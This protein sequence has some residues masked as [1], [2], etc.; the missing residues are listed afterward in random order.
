MDILTEQLK[1]EEGL[2]LTAYP[3]PTG[4]KTIGYGHNLEA[5]PFFEGNRIPD[6]ITKQVAEVLL[7]HD[8]EDT[9]ELLDKAWHGF[10]LLPGAR[11]DACVNMSFQMGVDKF[12][13]FQKMRDAL[14]RCDW[15]RAYIEAMNSTWARQTPERAER[16]ANQFR[17]GEYYVPGL[18]AEHL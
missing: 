4:H 15:Q 6:R 5:R 16:V 11:G 13:G 18:I 1:F 3:C 2:R 12:M 17:T 7:H 10:L 14:L 8:I 9:I